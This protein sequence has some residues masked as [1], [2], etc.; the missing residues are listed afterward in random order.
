MHAKEGNLNMVAPASSR[1]SFLLVYPPVTRPCEPPAGVSRLAGTLISHGIGCTVFDANL[2]CLLATLRKTPDLHDTWNRRAWSGAKAHLDSLR[3]RDTYSNMGRYRRAA[4]DLNRLLSEAGTSKGVHIGLT[5]FSSDALSPLK[6]NDL[7]KAAQD[8]EKS[9]FYDAFGPAIIEIIKRSGP[10]I[11]GF[12]LNYLAQAITCFSMIG[13][14]R[15][16]YADLKVILGGGLVTSWASR[17]GWKSPFEPLVDEMVCGPGEERLLAIAGVESTVH[18]YPPSYGWA[19][20]N[21]YLSPGFVLPYSAS[22]GCYWRRCSFCPEKAEKNPYRPIGPDR[23]KTE[24]MGI[25]REAAPALIHFLD[26]AM[27]PAFLKKLASNPP[28]APWYGFARISDLLAEEDFTLSLK[29]SGCVM[30]KLGIESGDQHVLDNMGKGIEIKTVS[31]VLKALKRA[32]I[33]SYVYLLFGTPAEDEKKALNTLD[34]V[35]ANEDLIDYL[36]LAVFNMPAWGSDADVYETSDFYEGDLALYKDFVH[37]LGW[38]RL[39]VR[40][41]LDR[42]FRRHGAVASILRRE[43]PFFTSSHAPFFSMAARGEL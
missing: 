12:S 29:R 9:F 14:I 24:I 7:M 26:N 38:N 30:L 37:P 32:G 6:S 3:T 27:S 34:F 39:E 43:P 42:I 15:K 1:A 28:G 25:V 21:Q 22:T 11:V 2:H 35:A 23:V 20:G 36:N 17:P 19:L 31:S 18:A 33:A 16:K 13:F 5:N 4:Q 40:R 8:P 41:F 10:S